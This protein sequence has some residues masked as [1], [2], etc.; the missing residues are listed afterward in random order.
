MRQGGW[1]R[2]RRGQWL[3]VEAGLFDP[4]NLGRV[5][6]VEILAVGRDHVLVEYRGQ[7]HAVP[8]WRGYL[9]ARFVPRLVD[10]THQPGEHTHS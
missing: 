8:R 2:L 7:R 10:R 6:R 1:P 4:L 3:E 9:G 5:E